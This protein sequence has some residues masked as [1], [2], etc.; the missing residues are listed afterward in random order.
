MV[1][2]YSSGL[3]LADVQWYHLYWTNLPAFLHPRGQSQR[4]AHLLKAI[5]LNRFHIPCTCMNSGRKCCKCQFK[6]KSFPRFFK[7]PST[8]AF[9]SQHMASDS[10][11]RCSIFRSV[12]M[13]RQILTTKDTHH[14]WKS[15][16]TPFNPASR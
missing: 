10:S 9:C 2:Q 5:A 11:N 12:K 6:A 15:G 4:S 7:Q 1:P 16:P 8:M 14:K 3:L 13:A